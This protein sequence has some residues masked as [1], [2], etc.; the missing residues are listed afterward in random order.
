MLVDG[1]RTTTTSITPE[2][3]T[4][5]DYSETSASDISSGGTSETSKVV[6][7]ETRSGATETGFANQMIMRDF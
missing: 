2:N 4:D 1:T 6:V 7:S 5:Y 3:A